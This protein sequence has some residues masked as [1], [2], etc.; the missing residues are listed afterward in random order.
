L[1][2][3]IISGIIGFALLLAVVFLGK[4][5]LSISAFLLCV[6]GLHEFYNALHKGGYKPVRPIGYLWSIFI[7]IIGLNIKKIGSFN[8][9][10][11]SLT[12]LTVIL[13]VTIVVL[14]SVIIFSNNKYNIIDISLTIF[15]VFY[16]VFM[17]S[18]I[19]LTRNLDNGNL[20]IWLV[21]IGAFATD[22]F[23]YFTGKA[24]GRTKILPVIS[25]KKTL[26]GSI[27]GIVGCIIVSLLYGIFVNRYITVSLYHFI[28][29]GALS[30]FVSQIGDWSASSIKRFVDVKDYGNVMPGHGGVLDRFDSILFIAPLVYFYITIVMG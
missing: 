4:I 26:E 18:F 11:N 15:G 17:F 8:I 10:D 23:A 22:T 14:F 3:R 5:S 20:F 2:T 24:L 28:I 9:S 1:K 30:G 13:F 6:I 7:L 29:I 16:I 27:G 21:F 12:L 25:S 19:V